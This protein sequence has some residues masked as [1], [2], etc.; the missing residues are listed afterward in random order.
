[1]AGIPIERRALLLG[2]TYALIPATAS[3]ARKLHVASASYSWDQFFAREQR[4][5]A[6]LPDGGFGEV[7]RS[8]MDGYECIIGSPADIDRLVPL[9][10][11]HGLA[12]RSLYV[13]TELHRPE[14]A[15]EN[16][17][18]VVEIASRAKSQAGTE[19]VV[20][21]P[22]P[23]R[24]GGSE[25]KDD[26]QLKLQAEKLDALGAELRRLELTLAYHT[27]DVEMRK[28]AREFHHM[29]L[30]TSPSNVALCLDVHWIYRGCG[31]SSVALFDIVRLYGARIRELH[32]RQSSGGVWAEVFGPGD[33]D[34]P[35]LVAEL[36]RLEVRPHLV[37]EQAPEKGTPQTLDP[38][39]LHR[40]SREYVDR[41]F[42]PLA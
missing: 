29:M 1:M 31:N 6:S 12:M 40:R 34:Y 38:V 42:A 39:E 21:N 9:L 3:P 5:F 37:L 23:I 28:A 27:H 24:W 18:R 8:G 17:R 16:I 22:S 25:D 33:I 26:G 10:G 35:A 20:T 15:D 7:A 4:K 2:A 41:V 11:K 32:L 36:V 30:A 14:T 13:N 19:F